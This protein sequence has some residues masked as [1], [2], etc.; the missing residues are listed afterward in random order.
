MLIWHE[1]VA[2]GPRGRTSL[3]PLLRTNDL[4]E[5]ML[6]NLKNSKQQTQQFRS[7]YTSLYLLNIFQNKVFK[8]LSL[9]TS[10][11]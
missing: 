2:Y 10:W 1:K 11:I 5:E 4:S 9:R 6:E 7:L 8:L 3:D